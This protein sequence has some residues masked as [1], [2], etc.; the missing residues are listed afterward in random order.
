MIVKIRGTEAHECWHIFDAKGEVKYTQ[1]MLSVND[2]EHGIPIL[3]SNNKVC[4][5]VSVGAHKRILS[6]GDFPEWHE[7]NEV[8][9]V[10]GDDSPGP[11]LDKRHPCVLLSIIKNGGW[12]IGDV[13]TIL[14]NTVAYICNDEGRTIE[15]VTPDWTMARTDHAAQRPVKE[16]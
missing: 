8:K 5:S 15:K 11:D 10:E 2:I 9:R 7:F 6:A 1:E 12:E 4:G 3:D 16:Q 13:Y 14:F